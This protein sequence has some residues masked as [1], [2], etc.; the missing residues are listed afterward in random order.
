MRACIDTTIPQRTDEYRRHPVYYTLKNAQKAL[1]KSPP[2]LSRRER[3]RL[4]VVDRD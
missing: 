4:E 1:Q 2:V 3:G